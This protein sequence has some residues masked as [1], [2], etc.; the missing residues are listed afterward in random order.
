MKKFWKLFVVAILLLCNIKIVQA[1]DLIQVPVDNV[2]YVRR[3]GS[4]R[5]FS[6]KFHEYS[7]DG[8]T[9]YCIEP[10]VH[11]TTLQ[12]TPNNGMTISP[13]S[14]EVNRKLQLI[15]YYGYDYPTHHTLKYRMATQALIW[16]LTGNGIVEYWSEASGNGDFINI[17][18]EKDAIND[19]IAKHDIL[20]SFNG[21]NK[22]T[23]INSE[24]TF[25][26]TNNVL[27]NFEIINSSEFEAYI[28]GNVLHVTPHTVGTI[29]INLKRKSYTS[30][31]TTLYAGIDEVSQKMGYF[32]L[33]EDTNI[34]IT[35]KSIGSRVKI[36]KMDFY[37]QS[38]KPRGDASLIGAVFGIYKEDNTRISEIEIGVNCEG[39]S[40]YLP[41]GTYYIMEEKAGNG[42]NVDINQTFFTIT[43]DSEEIINW[44]FYNIPTDY[45]IELYKVKG[46]QN[47]ILSAEENITFEFYLKSTG[48][49]YGQ[50]TTDKNGQLIIYLPFGTYIVKQINTTPGYKKVADFEITTDPN[51]VIK[52]ISD[53]E[54]STRLK[55]IKIDSTTKKPI[56]ID[57]IKFKIK[58]LDT[59]KY[60]CQKINYPYNQEI[61]EF[62]TTDGYFILPENLKFGNYQIEEVENQLIPGY[63]WNS[64]PLKFSIN[65]KSNFIQ[66]ENGDLLLEIE[67]PN[68]PVKGKV[69]VYKL[70]EKLVIKDNTF[71]YEEIKLDGVTYE[72]YADDDIYSADGTLIY[73]K[74]DLI[75]T[76][77]TKNGELNITDLYLGKYYLIETKTI[78]NHVLDA[79]KHYFEIKYQDQYTEEVVIELTFKNYLKKG[80]LNFNK[81]DLNT[82]ENLANTK[83][84][85]YTYDDDYN[86]ATLIYEGYTD[87][88][89]NINID[90]LF[91]G[92]YY[93]VESVAP[94][95]Y[96]LNP[97]KLF[98][99][100]KDNDEIITANMTN[101]RVVFDVPATLDNSNPLIN[102][103]ILIL[104]LSTSLLIYDKK[105]KL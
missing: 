44:D 35:V 94:E 14:P 10:G 30:N 62:T 23:S 15:G 93:L 70:G 86:N 26:D 64:K 90:N 57:S 22:K 105:V 27:D 60:I 80:K 49:L 11:I 83:I 1:S 51:N 102:I 79:T 47:G 42:Y 76:F 29:T 50:G 32:G 97:T 7:I 48:E 73:Q 61:C 87:E 8:L 63:L 18:S 40:E 6:A 103:G 95:G 68:T 43:E 41:L 19:L 28:D 21:E 96:V 84:A 36:K 67:F 58:N 101:E 12:Y 100:I 25:E 45:R 81:K 82:N 104:S 71:Y 75:N 13:Y 72:L 89:G 92:K 53:E 5:Y 17:K 4:E 69:N 9:T 33:I 39:L 77:I 46:G 38:T 37:T 56:K 99:E 85:I 98:F 88:F 66:D 59:N 2:W 55:V 74:G 54:I 78:D 3:G 52:V 24:V 20:P 65:E 31:T 34:S 91:I 16:E